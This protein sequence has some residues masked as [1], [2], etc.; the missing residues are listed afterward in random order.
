MKKRKN[1]MLNEGVYD[2]YETLG[3]GKFTTDKIISYYIDKIRKDGKESL[4]AK[5]I[6]VFNDANRGELPLDKPVYK[7]NKLTNDIEMDRGVPIRIDQERLIPGLPFLTSKGKGGQQKERKLDARC[8]WYIGDKCRNYYIYDPNKKEDENPNGL[9]VY[10]TE[11]ATGKEFGTFMIPKKSEASKEIEELWS[12]LN[13]RYDKGI[14][15]N[16]EA[17]D[18]FMMFDNLYHASR[19]ENAEKLRELLNYLKNFPPQKK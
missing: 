6:E 8:Y 11:S 9:I 12:E 18:K 13:E 3:D 7:R 2:F 19:K 15:L 14:I 1:Q 17:Y 16:K 5:E 4:S 10:K